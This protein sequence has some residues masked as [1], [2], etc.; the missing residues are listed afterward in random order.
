MPWKLG[1]CKL[2]N[3]SSYC[4]NAG[5]IFSY[6]ACFPWYLEWRKHYR[7]NFHSCAVFCHMNHDVAKR[8]GLESC[9]LNIFF[10]V[11]TRGNPQLEMGRVF[12]RLKD[13]VVSILNICKKG[14]GSKRTFEI[15]AGHHG[16][17]F[18]WTWAQVMWHFLK[19]M[20]RRLTSTCGTCVFLIRPWRVLLVLNRRPQIFILHGEGLL[21]SSQSTQQ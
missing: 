10:K 7:L 20:E 3:G 5:A 6:Y 12:T 13:F 16:Q 4:M 21:G 8:F 9:L 1:Q 19:S 14:T 2:F 18:I 15:F 17:S 11:C